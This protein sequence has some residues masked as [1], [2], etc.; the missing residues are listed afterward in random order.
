MGEQSSRAQKGSL[1]KDLLFFGFSLLNQR[2]EKKV[3]GEVLSLS[4][5]L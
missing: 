1:E 2:E 4:A 3:W 5:Y